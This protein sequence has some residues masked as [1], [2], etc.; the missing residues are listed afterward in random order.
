M[1]SLTKRAYSQAP[2]WNINWKK[3]IGL[4]EKDD[5]IEYSIK[6]KDC[7]IKNK[8]PN[9]IAILGYG[10]F[11]FATYCQLVLPVLP[12]ANSVLQSIAVGIRNYQ[13]IK[14]FRNY[15]WCINNCQLFTRFVMDINEYFSVSMCTTIAVCM[16][17]LQSR[18]GAERKGGYSDQSCHPCPPVISSRNSPAQNINIKIENKQNF[19]K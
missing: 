7:Q 11:H 16:F 17:R 3:F 12:L 15:P 8:K 2:I 10:Y 1:F 9:F 19:S 18:A 6:L 13:N 14:T 5:L 4:S